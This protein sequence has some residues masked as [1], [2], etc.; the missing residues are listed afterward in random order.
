[1]TVSQSLPKYMSVELVMLSNHRYYEEDLIGPL[2]TLA[3]KIQMTF[4][5]TKLMTPS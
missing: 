4:F 2:I 1:M 5:L 3:P